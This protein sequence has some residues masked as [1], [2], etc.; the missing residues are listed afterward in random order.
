MMMKPMENSKEERQRNGFID[1]VYET[2]QG[3]R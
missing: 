2:K 1:L 3:I